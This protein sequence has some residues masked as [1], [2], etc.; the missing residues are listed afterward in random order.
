MAVSGMNKQI[1]EALTTNKAK[2]EDSEAKI[3][4]VSI[5]NIVK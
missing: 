5:Y 4:R 2:E 1:G 3:T